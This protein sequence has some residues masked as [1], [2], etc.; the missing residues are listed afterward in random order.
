MD[1]EKVDRTAFK[2]LKIKDVQSDFAFCQIQSLEQRLATLE[3]IRQEYNGWK[4]G[5]K[6]GFQRVYTVIKRK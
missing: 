3:K 5:T 6:Q 2:K 4:Y 1:I